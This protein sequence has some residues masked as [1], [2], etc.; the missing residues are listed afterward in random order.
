MLDFAFDAVIRARV[1]RAAATWLRFNRGTWLRTDLCSSTSASLSFAEARARNGNMR[2]SIRLWTSHPSQEL[3]IIGLAIAYAATVFVATASPNLYI[4]TPSNMPNRCD[5]CHKTFRRIGDLNSHVRQSR[6][7]HWL[8]DLRQQ[9]FSAPPIDYVEPDVQ[10]DDPPFDLFNDLAALEVVE[11]EDVP[12]DEPPREPS[13]APPPNARAQRATVEEALDEEDTVFEEYHGAA[14][15]VGWDDEV[16]RRY[17][18]TAGGVDN[19]WFP[20][21]SELEWG[22]AKWAKESDTGDNSLNRLLSIPG[23]VEGLGLTFRNA[24]ALNQRIDHEMPNT[25]EWIQHIVGVDRCTEQC[26]LYSRNILKCLDTLYSNPRFA[27]TMHYAPERHF[28]DG[29]KTSRMYRG[30][31]TGDWTWTRQTQIK[32]GGT[33]LSVIFATDKTELTLFSGEH[34]AYPLYMTLGNIDQDLRVRPSSYAW[35]LVGYLP[36]AKLDNV[37]LSENAARRARARLFHHCMKIIVEPLVDAG[38]NGRMMTSG[39][40]AIRECFPIL[41]CYIGD[42]PEQ[43]LVCCTRS[44]STC[45]K[46]PARKHE[47]GEDF[48]YDLRKPSET[49]G[50]IRQACRKATEKER[51]AALKAAGLTGV[52]EPFWERLPLCN[53]HEAITS[54]VLHQ[55]YQGVVKHCVEWVR[56][57]M[58]DTELDRRFQRMPPTHGVRVFDE[59]ISK[60]QRVS[61]AEHKEICKQLLG[62]MM[63]RAPGGAIRATRALLDFLYLA[64]YQS[65]STETL[66]YMEKALEEFHKHKAVFINLGARDG[67]N[68]NLPKLHSLQHYVDCIRLFGTTGN[69]DTALSERLHIDFVKDAYRSSNKKDAV[70]QM[71]RWLRR[72][73]TVHRFATLVEW[74]NRNSQTEVK[75]KRKARIGITI[76]K[77]PAVRNVSIPDVEKLYGATRFMEALQTYIGQLREGQPRYRPRQRDRNIVLVVNR[78]DVW[79][80]VKFDSADVQ[81][82]T[83]TVHHIARSHGISQPKPGR[84]NNI[85]P[86]RHDVVLVNDTGA[87]AVGLEGLRVARLRLVFRIPEDMETATFG[88][89]VPPPEHLAYVE[90]FTHPRRPDP[91]SKMYPITYGK[92]ANGQRDSAVIEV[93]NIVRICH[94]LPNFGK[95]VNINWTSASVLDQCEHFMIGNWN[96]QLAYQTLY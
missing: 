88:E 50:E 41:A 31:H 73:E 6:S 23:V 2:P 45:P 33:V 67:D 19:P 90:W 81:I 40:G 89:G 3:C 26:S 18:E 69:Y 20:F 43:C 16:R 30:I 51:E 65:H 93:K 57:I 96:D 22:I 46:C 39:D 60:L 71:G 82:G 21:A 54:D 92:M 24:R 12:M 5:A 42:N 64:R 8:L 80:V 87:E 58:T 13:A 86:A 9:E 17:Q 78:V 84:E 44:G 75:P 38:K 11:D 37:G 63:G 15:V 95:K 59:G 68:F 28:T 27:E 61:G 14:R 48:Y 25:P 49:L 91:D 94:I 35:I 34:T 85:K 74:R 36:V 66:E 76:A 70:E 52:D 62:C 47:F 7:C 1:A 29:T 83:N 55:L 56:N 77:K 53:I 10:E 72:R 79:H 32:R 4:G